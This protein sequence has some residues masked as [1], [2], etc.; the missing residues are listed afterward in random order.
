MSDFVTPVET[1]TEKALFLRLLGDKPAPNNLEGWEA[2]TVQYNVA[3]HEALQLQPP[4]IGTTL[5]IKNAAELRAFS[6]KLSDR[7]RSEH[8]TAPDAAAAAA[9]ATLLAH[10]LA[11]T[12]GVQRME[13]AQLR[14]MPAP[15]PTPRAASWLQPPP[16]AQKPQGRNAPRPKG[17]CGWPSRGHPLKREDCPNQHNIKPGW[18]EA[19]PLPNGGFCTKEQERE[20]KRQ[21][22]ELCAGVIRARTSLRQIVGP[23]PRRNSPGCPPPRLAPHA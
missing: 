22:V 4:G 8:A 10:T 23:G 5:R 14:G 6:T 2:F 20:N 7:L 12:A 1:I 11:S 13:P 16:P 19:G 3:V 18:P 17:C 9:N 21:R 15:T